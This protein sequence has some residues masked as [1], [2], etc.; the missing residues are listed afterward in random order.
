[1]LTYLKLIEC[2][3]KYS[4]Y[5]KYTYSIKSNYVVILFPKSE[6]HVSIFKDQWDEYEF[7]TGKPYYQFHV[8]SNNI[9]QRCSSYF[10][11]KKSTNRI[12]K[13]PS[14][15]FYYDQPVY[16]INESTRSPCKLRKIMPILK[17]F[18]KF[19]KRC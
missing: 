5:R 12:R 4:K 3:E 15:Y 18:Q 17:L 1:M 19:L 13:I 7:L 11:V 10:W 16:S 2:L 8:S 14:K 6:Y 9:D